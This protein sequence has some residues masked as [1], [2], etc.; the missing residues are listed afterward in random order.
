[1]SNLSS[2]EHKGRARMWAQTGPFRRSFGLLCFYSGDNLGNGCRNSSVK[3]PNVAVECSFSR[4]C[5]LGSFSLITR[6]QT[7]GHGGNVCLLLLETSNRLM[8]TQ[9]FQFPFQF[10]SDN[11]ELK[12]SQWSTSILHIS[13]SKYWI[14]IRFEEPFVC[15]KDWCRSVSANLLR[16]IMTNARLLLHS[17]MNKSHPFGVVGGF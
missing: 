4:N 7:S 16:A 13:S 5:V 8:Q 15:A 2:A 1:M 10:H 12:I 17:I 3:S 6:R 14:N 11:S 9:R